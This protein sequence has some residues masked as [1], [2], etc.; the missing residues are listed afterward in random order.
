MFYRKIICANG[1]C[2][3]TIWNTVIVVE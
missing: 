1:R 3:L 2:C